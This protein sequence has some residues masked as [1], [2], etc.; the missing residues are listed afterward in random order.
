MRTIEADASET[1]GKTDFKTKPESNNAVFSRLQ[2][3]NVR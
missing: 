3:V 1:H 2:T